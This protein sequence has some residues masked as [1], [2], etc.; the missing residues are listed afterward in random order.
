MALELHAKLKDCEQ[1]GRTER[2]MSSECE[3]GAGI[4]IAY[5]HLK[6]VIKMVFKRSSRFYRLKTLL[7][8]TP[9]LARGVGPSY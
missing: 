5:D 6:R 8:N 4:N 9:F 2:L 7:I 1:K 3:E